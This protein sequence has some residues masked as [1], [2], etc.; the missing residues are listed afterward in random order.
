LALRILYKENNQNE[1]T[2]FDRQNL[3]RKLSPNPTAVS[4]FRPAVKRAMPMRAQ[5][6]YEYERTKKNDNFVDKSH[7]K[8]A[9][10]L[11]LPV[12]LRKL[13]GVFVYYITS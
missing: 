6:T 5:L 9:L 13:G 2:F 3:I 10:L 11:F 4:N 7:H 8:T 1:K 12:H